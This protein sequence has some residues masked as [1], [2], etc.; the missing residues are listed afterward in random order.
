MTGVSSICSYFGIRCNFDIIL[1]HVV[2]PICCQILHRQPL[3]HSARLV[4]TRLMIE[5]DF[6]Y[7][8]FPWNYGSFEKPYVALLNSA[9]LASWQPLLINTLAARG[10][11]EQYIMRVSL[12]FVII[13]S[14]MLFIVLLLSLMYFFQRHSDSRFM[15]LKNNL[16]NLLGLCHF[17]LN[18]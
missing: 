15:I 5:L 17:P 2:G 9:N 1:N 7:I 11:E 6:F 18:T 12:I 13:V 4:E 10:L 8:Y 16:P 3:H 14:F